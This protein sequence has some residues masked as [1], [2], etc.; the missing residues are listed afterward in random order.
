MYI[1]YKATHKLTGKIYIGYTKKDLQ[2]RI[3]Q[4][5]GVIESKRKAFQIFLHTTKMEDWSWEILHTFQTY[6]EARDSEMYYIKTLNSYAYGL[7]CPTGYG[8][9]KMETYRRLNSE[10]LKNYRAQNPEPWNK[11]KTGIYSEETL[12]LMRLAKLKNPS[13]T[14]YT[15]ALKQQKSLQ[16]PNRKMVKELKTG[17]IFNSISQAAKFF[18]LSREAVRD[19]V[20]GHRTH[21]A[22]FVFIAI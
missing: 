1:V 13:K 2:E 21:T 12:N 4:H 20:N 9:S 6:K 7:N 5:W 16:A 17:Q 3:G 10:R 18:K 19:V 11:G 22:G 15:E 8:S 14:V